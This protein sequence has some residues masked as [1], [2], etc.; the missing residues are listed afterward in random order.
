MTFINTGG[1]SIDFPKTNK[2]MYFAATEDG[3]IHRCSVSYSEQ[4]LESYYGHSGPVY[5]VRCSPFWSQPQCQIFITCSY[6]W[7]I[8]VWNQ[9]EGP[10]K[11]MKL[12]C[13]S[14]DLQEQ[15]NDV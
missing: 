6:D 5:K 3:S 8:R 10:G 1:L 13:Q 12:V 9:L 14:M 11:Q 7:T 15:V 4:A 2:D